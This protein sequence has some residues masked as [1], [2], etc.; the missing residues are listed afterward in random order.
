MPTTRDQALVLVAGSDLELV[1]RVA[2]MVR[3]TGAATCKAS[4]AAGCLRV[5]TAV[6]PDVVLLD[7]RFSPKVERLL[8]AHPATARSNIVRLHELGAQQHRRACPDLG[9]MPWLLAFDGARS[10]ELNA[11][12]HGAVD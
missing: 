1:D 2:E 3:S 8:R 11:A 4:S 5:A 7:A 12:G 10:S 6:G 9:R